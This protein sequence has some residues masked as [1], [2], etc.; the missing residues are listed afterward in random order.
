MDLCAY[1]RTC[2]LRVVTAPT[3]SL[4]DQVSAFRFRYCT[5][6]RP[7]DKMLI[8]RKYRSKNPKY[9]ISMQYLKYTVHIYLNN[10]LQK[11]RILSSNKLRAYNINVY[12]KLNIKY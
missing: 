11:A 2:E 6:H 5:I 7:L 8:R 3:T 9:N 12:F 4:P 1:L 10:Y